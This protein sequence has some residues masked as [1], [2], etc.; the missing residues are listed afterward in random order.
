MMNL[1]LSSFFLPIEGVDQ[2]CGMSDFRMYICVCVYLHLLIV[3]DM[4][5]DNLVF[6][7]LVLLVS[8]LPEPSRKRL[9]KMT[10]KDVHRK[11]LN[12][13]LY[14]HG[15]MSRGLLPG[16]DEAKVCQRM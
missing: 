8:R 10:G 6:G 14:F 9:G 16:Y 13:F 7:W 11:F 3:R 12:V 5:Y 2:I 15:N 1:M 4:A